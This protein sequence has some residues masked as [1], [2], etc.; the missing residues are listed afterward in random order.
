L[1]PAI[2]VLAGGI[3]CMVGV[4]LLALLL[5]TLRVYDVRSPV[6][7]PPAATIIGSSG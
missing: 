2:A 5:P 4:S 1:T 6:V 7:E 3:L